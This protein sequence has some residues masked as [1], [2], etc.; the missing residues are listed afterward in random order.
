M[1]KKILLVCLVSLLAINLVAIG[2]PAPAP[3]APAP[4]APPAPAPPPP[5]EPAMEPVVWTLAANYRKG[6]ATDDMFV[7]NYLLSRIIYEE[8]GGLIRVDVK[9]ELYPPAETL[10][11]VAD[12]RVEIGHVTLNNHIGDQPLW[13]LSL[14]PFLYE[15]G[16]QMAYSWLYSLE[17]RKLYQDSLNAIGVQ[18]I[19]FFSPPPQEIWCEEKP[20]IE[21]DDFK[22]QKIRTS[23]MLQ[24]LA[25]APLKAVNITIPFGELFTSMERGII[26]AAIT[27]CAAGVSI[28]LQD[29]CK[30]VVAWPITPTQPYIIAVNKDVFDA[31]PKYLQDAVMRAGRQASLACTYG[32]NLRWKDS[33]RIAEAAGVQVLSPSAAEIQKASELMAEA[34]ESWFEMTGDEGRRWVETVK[35]WQDK[36]TRAGWVYGY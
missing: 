6:N 9:N 12:G 28:G 22:G 10:Y 36:D 17:V 27:S 5:V 23:S 21:V 31:L 11:A 19:A 34:Y 25:L 4:P 1:K 16:A 26:D 2:C 18:Q 15:N 7:P 14:L 30:A 8:T 24:A 32:Y 35:A 29:L 33:H 3:P 13:G 20:I